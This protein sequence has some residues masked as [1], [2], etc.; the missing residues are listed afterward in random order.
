MA[1]FMES[2][3]KGRT[4]EKEFGSVVKAVTEKLAA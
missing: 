1:K 2:M 3:G 4:N